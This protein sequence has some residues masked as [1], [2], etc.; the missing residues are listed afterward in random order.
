M[1]AVG[2]PDIVDS[3]E[4]CIAGKSWAAARGVVNVVLW[5][6]LADVRSC[7]GP[8]LGIL[9]VL[10]VEGDLIARTNKLQS[11]VSVSIAGSRVR[12]LPIKE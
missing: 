10:T 6:K 7:Y 2:R 12:S 9:S 3:M 4:K 5:S 8:G 1:A 11:P